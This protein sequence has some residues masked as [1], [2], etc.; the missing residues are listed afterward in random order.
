MIRIRGESGNR[1]QFLVRA[2]KEGVSVAISHPEQT[3]VASLLTR[4]DL[5]CALTQVRLP[6]NCI[7]RLRA[8]IK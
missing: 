5:G 4:P 7:R 2:K 8:A 3:F 1:M 6:R